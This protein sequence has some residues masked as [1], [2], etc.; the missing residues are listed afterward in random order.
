MCEPFLFGLGE[1]FIEAIEQSLV[2]LG[3]KVCVQHVQ[4]LVTVWN[5]GAAVEYRS[6]GA[7]PHS[8]SSK[9]ERVR[10]RPNGPE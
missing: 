5:M 7:T 4:S 6:R 2:F 8:R 9:G 10:P 1:P 3:H